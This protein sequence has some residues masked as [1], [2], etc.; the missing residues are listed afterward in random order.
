MSHIITYGNKIIQQARQQRRLQKPSTFI[1]DVKKYDQL[2]EQTQNALSNNEQLNNILSDI[3]TKLYDLNDNYISQKNTTNTITNDIIN[4]KSQ[5][6]N[7][8]AQIN[9]LIKQNQALENYIKD[10]I[11]IQSSSQLEIIEPSN[12]LQDFE[13][14]YQAFI[15]E[16]KKKLQL[17][18]ELLTEIKEYIKQQYES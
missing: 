14:E 13:Q 11:N 3:K 17:K 12:K 15:D 18:N 5:I 7:L 2:V 9:N 10:N 4:I 8:Q 1:D 6:S 16:Q